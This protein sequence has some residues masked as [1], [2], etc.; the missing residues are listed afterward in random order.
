[1]GIGMERT[2]VG[3][4]TG[5]QWGKGGGIGMRNWNGSKGCTEVSSVIVTMAGP[6]SP[7]PD[8]D[9]ESKISAHSNRHGQ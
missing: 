7:A 8:G 4:R 6:F 1:M 3:I 2:Q 5:K 9:V